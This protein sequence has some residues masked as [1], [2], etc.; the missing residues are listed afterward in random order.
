MDTVLHNQ[1]LANG[2]LAYKDSKSG[3]LNIKEY[4]KFL[5][6]Y[7][8]IFFSIKVGKIFFHVRGKRLFLEIV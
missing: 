4:D 1:P 7:K 3:A 6:S 5:K 8:T 2:Q